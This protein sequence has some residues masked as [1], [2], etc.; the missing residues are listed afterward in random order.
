MKQIIAADH[1]YVVA[2]LIL[3]DQVSDRISQLQVVNDGDRSPGAELPH[4]PLLPPPPYDDHEITPTEDRGGILA[5]FTDA[6]RV[7]GSFRNG[8]PMPRTAPTRSK[9][10]PEC[11]RSPR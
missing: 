1:A 10:S 2:G 8:E 9:P 6:N 4:G 7:C 3:P 5:D 11:S